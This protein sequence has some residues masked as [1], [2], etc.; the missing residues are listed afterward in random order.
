MVRQFRHRIRFFFVVVRSLS[1]V[2]LLSA[3]VARGQQESIVDLSRKGAEAMRAGRFADAEQIFRNLTRRYPRE[4]P[5]H[6]NLGLAL[7]SQGKL[8]EAAE[9]I[10]Y[11][12]KLQPN[13]GLATVLGIDYLKLGEPC[14]AIAP[15]E[16]TDRVEALA[17]AY[18]GCKRYVEAG[19]LY[20]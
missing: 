20:E 13:A 19:R 17:D 4:A 8:R 11:S 16:K 1:T 7:H 18:T 12:L 6:G 14:R 3:L 2:V 10:E 9:S 15:L 5:W